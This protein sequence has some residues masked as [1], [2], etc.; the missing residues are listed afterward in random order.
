MSKVD[1]SS[2]PRQSKGLIISTPL[3]VI[4]KVKESYEFRRER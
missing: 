3:N 2:T 1:K 4:D